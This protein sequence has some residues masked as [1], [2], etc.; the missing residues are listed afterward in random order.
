MLRKQKRKYEDPIVI[1][2]GD[3]NQWAIQGHLEDFVDMKEIVVGPTRGDRAIDCFFS[4]LDHRVVG[5]VPPLE[6]D[7]HAK[8]SDHKV[9]FFTSEVRRSQS[10]EW[11]TYSYRFYNSDSADQFGRWL[12]MKD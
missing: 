11:M 2:A 6:T 7:D 3:F 1:V 12:A 4:N 9:C 10:F 8:K 5:T